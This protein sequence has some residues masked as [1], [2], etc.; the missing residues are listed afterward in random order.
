[1]TIYFDMDGTLANFYGVNGWLDCLNN[2]DITPYKIAKPL[3]KMNVLARILNNL[4]KRGFEIGIISWTAKNS[5]ESY[6][7]A[8]ARTK[9]QWLHTHLK[10]VKFNEI[11]ILEYGVPKSTVATENDILFDDDKRVRKE[12]CGQA[13]D[14]TKIFA[15]LKAL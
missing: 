13:F 5:S 6:H 1:M 15:L 8:V 3:I 11:N 4:Q 14:E 2:E 9:E 7:K 12:W 10:S